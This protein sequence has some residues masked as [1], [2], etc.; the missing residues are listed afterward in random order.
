M[1]PAS[2]QRQWSSSNSAAETTVSSFLIRHLFTDVIIC[3][4]ENVEWKEE[5][6]SRDPVIKHTVCQV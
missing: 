4:V 5:R 2:L 3:S 1:N 6:C